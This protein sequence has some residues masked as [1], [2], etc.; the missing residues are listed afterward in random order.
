MHLLHDDRTT[1]LV[2]SSTYSV[3]TSSIT[4]FLIFSRLAYATATRKIQMQMQMQMQ[5]RVQNCRLQRRFTNAD[6]KCNADTNA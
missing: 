5:I 2:Q 6:T 3:S 1:N 4:D